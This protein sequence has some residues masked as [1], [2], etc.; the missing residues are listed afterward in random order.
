M[1]K[2]FLSKNNIHYVEKN[3]SLDHEAMQ[4]LQSRNIQGVP[5]FLIGEDMVVGLDQQK[6]LKLVDHRVMKCQNCSQKLRVPVNKGK[7]DI[8]CPKCS[9]KNT[10]NTASE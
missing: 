5:A 3:I 7:I 6:I 9:H 2:E 8:T 10:V 1:A 4:E